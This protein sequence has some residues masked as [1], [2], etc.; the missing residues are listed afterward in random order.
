MNMIRK[1]YR[2][3]R[4]LKY[5]LLLR[6]NF[7]SNRVLFANKPRISR[8]NNIMIKGCDIYFG[9]NC[10]IGAN[11]VLGNKVLI[12]SNVSF[13]GGDHNFELIGSFIKDSSRGALKDIIVKDDVWIGHG[14][15]ILHGVTIHEGAIVAAGSIVTKDVPPFC[16]VGGNPAK[17]IKNRFS[18][19][20]LEYHKKLIR[21]SLNN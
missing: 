3:Y 18:E 2:Q 4:M 11:L 20:Q 7:W 12:A 15:I 19:E 14:A 17:K 10:H 6:R 9:H 5:S 13:V 16:I 8:K 21:S 1:L